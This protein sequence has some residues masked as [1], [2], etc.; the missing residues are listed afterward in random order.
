[1]NC[2][3]ANF[4]IEFYITCRWQR[5]IVKIITLNVTIFYMIYNGAKH[6]IKVATCL[7]GGRGNSL[8]MIATCPPYRKGPIFR[9]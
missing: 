7:G 1:M 8:A 4:Y 9:S 3:L 2:L 6:L 5:I